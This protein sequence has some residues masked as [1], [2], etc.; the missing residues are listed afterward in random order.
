MLIKYI[1][2]FFPIL[3]F[4]SCQNK[5]NINIGESQIL[6]WQDGKKAAISIT[7]DGGTVN[8]FRI[9]LPVM[10]SLGFPASFFIVTGEI[11]GSEYKAKFIGRSI[12]EI[13][14]EV[15]GTPTDQDNIYER[16]SAMRFIGPAEMT[17]YHTRAGDLFETGKFEETYTLVDEAYKLAKGHKD[18]ISASKVQDLSS[19]ELVSWDQLKGIAEKGH[20][21]ASH[22]ISHPQFAILDDVN[23]RYELEKSK[24][25]IFNHLGPRHTFSFECP[26][27]TEN[28][29]V[30]EETFKVYAAA[31]N[32]M[33]ED[34]LEEIN[35]WNDMNP[36]MSRKEYV[37][38]QRGP[39]TR[40]LLETMKS[41]IDTC[42]S[43]NNIWLVLVFHGVEG[44]GWEAIP[45]ETL[46]NYF[47]YI[48][49]N[50]EN[51]WVATFQDVT[52]Y[53]RERMNAEVNVSQDGDKIH[54]SVLHNL[55]P[56]LYD[57]PLT[58]KTIIPD[59]WEKIRVSQ[60][61]EYLDFEMGYDQSGKFVIYQVRPN[62]EKIIISEIKT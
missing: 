30:M 40:T 60:N 25:E 56:E 9:A 14:R 26:Y 2:P 27:G 10:D 18:Q 13:V 5:E 15:S 44:V 34:F 29:R 19:S 12:E 57:L 16:A 37:Q 61:S 8:Q 22:S 49:S 36:G 52:K 58:V 1:I 17:E 28:D 35:R 20:E 43:H 51:V 32:R 4:F 48:K 33:P 42:V 3:L 23:L 59:D 54:V 47:E 21:F 53:I 62:Q 50:E 38:W 41:W 55:D 46:K 6:R 39:K 31:R 24:E 7:Y 45:G 11:P